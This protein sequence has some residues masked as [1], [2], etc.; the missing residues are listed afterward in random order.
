LERRRYL[1]E[2][3]FFGSYYSLVEEENHGCT[4][5]N[6]NADSPELLAHPSIAATIIG[7]KLLV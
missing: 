6:M 3:F 4:F 1:S 2:Y 7:I 5:H